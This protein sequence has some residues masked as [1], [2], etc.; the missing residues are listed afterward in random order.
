MDKQLSKKKLDEMKQDL[1]YILDNWFKNQYP[2]KK[3][4]DLYYNPKNKE[5]STE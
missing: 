4:N 1:D 3:K 2:G 5:K